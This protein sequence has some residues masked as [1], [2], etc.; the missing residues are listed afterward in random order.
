MART[1]DPNPLLNFILSYW[2]D[3]YKDAPQSIRYWEALV[4]L[5]DDE[6]AQMEQIDDASNVW[7][8]P[9][10]IYH[11]YLHRELEDWHSYGVP[12]FHYRKDF[13][14]TAG[15]TIFYMGAWVAPGEMAVFQDGKELDITVDPCAI[16]QAQ[17]ATQPG[18]NPAGSRLIFDNP[19]ILNQPISVFSRRELFYEEIEVPPGGAP[20]ILTV[21]ELDPYSVRVW[22]KKLNITRFLTLTASS[23]GWTSTPTPGSSDDRYFRAGEV[24]DVVDGATTQSISLA[25]DSATV[26]IPI[27]VNPLTAKI[28]RVYDFEIT[29]GSVWIDGKVLRA[30]TFFPLSQRIRATDVYGPLSVT[31]EAPSTSLDLGRAMDQAARV[32]LMSGELLE[33][34]TADTDGV[35]FPRSFMEGAVILVQASIAE[36]NDHEENHEVTTTV[37]QDLYVDTRHPFFL[38]PLLLEVPGFPIQVFI[39]GL[40]QH[41]D[42]YV[43][44][45]T[46][47]V[48]LNAPVPVGTSVDI[49]YVSLENPRSHRHIDERFT[50]ASPQAS[51]ALTLPVSPDFARFVSVDGVVVGDPL[52]RWFTPDGYFLTFRQSITTGSIVRVRGEKFSYLYYHD[53][54]KEL[55]RADYLQDGIDERSAKLPAGWTIQ[56]PWVDGFLVTDGLLEANAIVENAWFVNALVDEATAYNNF[57]QLIG[58]GRE[59]SDDYVR[60]LRA[61]F[62]G[63]Y[64]GSQHD[65]IES[66]ICVL[67]G[68]QYLTYASKIASINDGLVSTDR[69]SV[70]FDALVPLRVSAGET[71][72]RLTA[73]SSFAEVLAPSDAAKIPLEFLPQAAESV[74]PD[75]RFAHSLDTRKDAEMT[76]GPTDYYTMLHKLED[77]S[78]DFVE[79]NVWPGDLVKLT[80]PPAFVLYCRVVTVERTYL[81]LTSDLQGYP[82]GYGELSFGDWVY[83]GGLT[84]LNDVSYRIWTRDLDRLDEGESLDQAREDD[85]PYLND[86]VSQLLTPFNFV[87]HL[88][89]AGLRT[90]QSLLDLASFLERTCPAETGYFVYARA[91]EEAGLQDASEGTLTDLAPVRTEYPDYFYVDEGIAGVN[92]QVA[93]NAGSFVG[94]P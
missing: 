59:T 44:L 17:D 70:A 1:F 15:Q 93:P 6:W 31:V 56:L 77:L 2:K 24:F 40:L 80:R 8:C 92:G 5:M 50:V 13:R 82:T 41:P 37:T 61:M 27:P 90:E 16:T 65:T 81:I 72:E 23:F 22:L 58:F 71:V 36:P 63:S 9:S 18:V 86:R 46:I 76:G 73:V 79:A 38:T 60:I 94:A 64:M 19:R 66:L 21:R 48:S 83:G 49:H 87:V 29:K 20:D 54:D 12:H 51:F 4:R 57:G 43:F 67:M 14:A 45:S 32:Y 91:Y 62:S 11:T 28:Y 52:D 42:T 78:V 68:S 53:I 30:T 25:I 69:E 33:P 89:W 74:S 55:Q 84:I 34:Y 47:Q 7:T 26:A 75:Y 88:R 3:Y 10:F 39:D 85:I 35:R